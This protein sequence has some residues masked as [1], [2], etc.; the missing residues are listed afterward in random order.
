VATWTT[1]W[2][3]G[4]FG[5]GT[6]Y[7]LVNPSS[8]VVVTI[9]ERSRFR[10]DKNWGPWFRFRMAAPPPMGSGGAGGGGGVAIL[11]SGSPITKVPKVRWQWRIEVRI[12]DP[13]FVDASASI[14]AE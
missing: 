6:S 7:S 11:S 8:K 12:T 3:D 4:S 1:P 2:V 9:A 13:T 10:G 5:Y 14:S